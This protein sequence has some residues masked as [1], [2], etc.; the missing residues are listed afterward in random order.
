[1]SLLLH[2]FK[3]GQLRNVVPPNVLLLPAIVASESPSSIAIEVYPCQL[4]QASA[5]GLNII[6]LDT[7]ESIILEV[8]G[9]RPVPDLFVLLPQFGTLVFN[10]FF[11]ELAFQSIHGLFNLVLRW[12]GTLQPWMV[13]DLLKTGP[14]NHT[15]GKHLGNQIFEIVGE[16]S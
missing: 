6:C 14:V 12:S 1:M 16:L 3:F 9:E 7:E 5:Q 10:F 4:V 2:L 8:F 15:I 13:F 11:N